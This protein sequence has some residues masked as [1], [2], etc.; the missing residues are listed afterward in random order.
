MIYGIKNYND[1]ST[2]VVIKN[3]GGLILYT[4]TFRCEPDRIQIM[5]SGSSVTVLADSPTSHVGR[6]ITQ[7]DNTNVRMEQIPY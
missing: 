3:E 5:G 6:L 2:Q 1:G 7:V 4:E